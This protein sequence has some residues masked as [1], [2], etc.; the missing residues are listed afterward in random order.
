MRH[1]KITAR[2][3][4]CVGTEARVWG[5]DDLWGMLKSCDQSPHKAGRWDWFHLTIHCLH[6]K[7]KHT[8]YWSV[9]HPPLLVCSHQIPASYLQSVAFC[10]CVCVIFMDFSGILF[11]SVYL[12]HRVSFYS[13]L[14][15]TF[16]NITGIWLKHIFWSATSGSLLWTFRVKVPF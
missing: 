11:L 3:V 6:L 2:Y 4:I 13:P 1:C 5:G 12:Y 7:N 16:N 14:L 8:V 9:L 15:K 10:V